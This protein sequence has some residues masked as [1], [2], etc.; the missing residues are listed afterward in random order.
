MREDWLQAGRKL[1]FTT[2]CEQYRDIYRTRIAG[3]FPDRLDLKIPLHKGYLLL[4]PVG[5]ALRILHPSGAHTLTAQVV[6]RRTA[7]K[8]WSV[9]IPRLERREHRTQ[10]IAIG[11]GKGGVGKTTLSINLSLALCRLG[12]RVLLLDADIGMANVEVL[13]KLNAPRNLTDVLNGECSL[14]DVITEA[15]GGLK[16]IP[17]S[18]GISSL[19]SWDLLR[20][21]RIISGFADVED[22]FDIFVVDTGAGISELVLKFLE[23]ADS[24][25][26]TTT[27]EPHA[28]MD[29]YSAAKALALRG[30]PLNPLMVFNRCDSEDEARRCLEKIHRATGQF[31]QA[32]PE[33]QGRINP[34]ML[35]WIYEDKKVTQSLKNQNPLLLC[36]PDGEYARRV[37]E[38]AGR[39][40]G[41]SITAP[42]AATAASAAKPSGIVAFLQRIKRGLR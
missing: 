36:E 42:P 9:S 11:S 4:I 2:D 10:V 7:E 1:V 35:G 26:L 22:D 33:M 5:A 15:P 24:L 27:P 18:S 8:I 19:T 23:A 38:I 21:N 16:I 12:K 32:N 31:F 20:F 13:L 25:I 6:A 3:V 17:G 14:R 29:T 39:L 40:T 37:L 28:L 41:Q 30:S 34:E